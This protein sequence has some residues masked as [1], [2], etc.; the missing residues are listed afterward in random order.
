VTQRFSISLATVV[1]LV[2]LRLDIG[3][4]FFSEGVK[5]LV[6]PH[7]SSEP[8]LRAAKGPLAPLFQAYLPDF[9]HLG[10]A[11]HRDRSQSDAHTVESW[12][13]EIQADWDVDRQKFQDYYH[14]ND[15]QA[16]ETRQV[17]GH[18]QA[19]LRDWLAL[20]KDALVTHV[21]DWR[22]SNDSKTAPAGDL[23]FQ[24]KRFH[25]KQAVL[26]AEAASWRNELKGLE[27]DF[28]LGLESV[29]DAEQQAEVPPRQAVNEIEIVDDVMTYV[30][31]T[32]G[33]LLLLGLLT[34]TACVAGAVFLATVVMMQPFW[35]SDT[36]PT[37][38][39]YVE[40]FALLTLATTP[41]GRWAGLDFF[42][43]NFLASGRSST[44]G[45]SDVS[46]S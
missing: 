37:F 33:V 8:V 45:G 27:D 29:L 32:I 7:W 31:L 22:R 44:K 11:L 9:H 23:P 3:W 15:A 17:L 28:H 10:D 25:E 40:M 39:Q 18:H 36:A 16:K 13:D 6:D 2:L 34:R 5:H 1:M 41:V 38:N 4:H 30:I 42:I 26:K 46:A 21:H 14:L 20:N 35:V 19:R 24:E 12:M 43:H